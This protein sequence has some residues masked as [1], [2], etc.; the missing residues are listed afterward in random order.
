MTGIEKALPPVADSAH[1]PAAYEAFLRAK[2][3]TAPLSGF[4][5]DAADLHQNLKPHT[6]DA[7]LWALRGGR[8]G[9][10]LAF[11]L[12]KTRAQ[13]EIARQVTRR[14]GS[15][16]LIIIPLGVR[17]EFYRDAAALDM[18]VTYVRDDTE[19]ADA[20]PVIL[21][22]YE[23]VRDGQISREFLATL[24]MVSLDEASV[25]RGFGGTKT[26][27]EFMATLAGDDR[28]ASYSDRTAGIRFRF[29]AT[30]TPSPNQYIEL[31][32]YAAFLGIMDVGE[33]KTR[34][35]RRDSEKADNLVLHPHKEREFWLWC[36]SWGLFLQRPSDLGYSDEGYELPALDV[37]WHEV[38]S[39]H[40]GAGIERDGQQRM[41][42][43]AA[44]NLS[45]AARE[46]RDSLP[47]RIAKLMEIRSEDLDAH[48]I[49]W[50]DLEAERLAVEAAIPEIVT[51]YGTQDL[52][53]REEAI[54][55]FSDGEIPEIAA[56]PV[57]FG[58]GANFQ[59]HCWWA[60]FLGIGFKFNDFIQAIY[61]I[62]RF[63]Q[64][65]QV[66]VDIIHTEAERGVRRRLEEKWRRDNEQ[67]ARMSEIIREY[68]LAE[69]AMAAA[70]S[71]SLGV[72]RIEVSGPGYVLANNDCVAETAGMES[73]S[74]DL[75]LTSIPFS[76]QYEYSPS[77]NDFGH[78]D[79][80]AHFWRQ[81]RFLVPELLRV[82]KPGRVAA[83]HVKDRIV[84]GGINGLGFQTV[85]PFSDEC[86]AEFA[87]GGF[88]FLARK[89]I[90]T[91]VVRENN[92]TYRL[93]WTEQCKDGSRMG[94]GMPEYLLLFRKPPS[95]R[96]NGYADAPVVKGKPRSFRQ[97]GTECDFE[98][99]LRPVPGTGYSRG[100]WQLDAHGFTRSSGDRI[101]TF[102]EIRELP[103][104]QIYKVW[105][106]FNL[107]AVYDFNHHVR[108]A[109]ELDGIGKLP[110][111]FML[112]PPHSWHPDVWAD[113]A[114]MLTLNGALSADGKEPHLC[115]MQF[116][117]ADRVI[118]QFSMEGE[119]VY[120]PFGGVMTVPL[121][122]LRLR[123]QG[124]GAELSPGYFLDGCSYVRA[125]A[126]KVD[127]PGLFDFMSEEKQAEE[128]AP[129]VAGA[130]A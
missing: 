12:H 122:A 87:A 3:A 79:S 89:T 111:K 26:F 99:N 67:R 95:D 60:V 113:V 59:R 94:C 9:L 80:N 129:T 83:I 98:R 91:D 56:K 8:R 47:A 81:M 114:R 106:R 110:P 20:G 19:A 104:E 10:F 52:D 70:L 58:S 43:D 116:D 88:A 51:V 78:S 69:A 115:P 41:F 86:V 30:A 72:K 90:V 71:R 118:T 84:P 24:I 28:S 46:K 112:L 40:S 7:V 18:E 61:R 32:S 102:E 48:R 68:G 77:Y 64:P 16:A 49:I 75:I 27:R 17:Q 121:R 127:M 55:S 45:D 92:Q 130:A 44:M 53:E 57:M 125:E 15:Q 54:I 74:V 123:R 13:L 39:D 33:A 6:R 38:P 65:H 128:E 1:D 96:S 5:V 14:F 42:R 29:V 105:K 109:E 31:L 85:Y 76:T 22:N 62:Q 25:L 73:D 50:H 126:E 97:D 82:L 35:F 36:A 93:G 21:T 117:I 119:L 124:R 107:Q 11:G 2:V 4:E 100:R 103:A 108:I 23:R 34:F 120:D 66:R 37:R 101:L 63:Q